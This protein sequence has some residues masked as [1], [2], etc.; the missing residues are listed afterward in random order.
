MMMRAVRMSPMSFA[1][2]RI[3]ILWWLR[4]AL[5]GAKRHYFLGLDSG[6][7]DP[8]GP[9]VSCVQ[10]PLARLPRRHRRTGLSF[11]V[12]LAVILTAFPMVAPRVSGSNWRREC[13]TRY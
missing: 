7:H 2:L 11:A 13:L 9:M 12:N 8:V 5:D 4:V 3:S 1:S 10:E 6:M